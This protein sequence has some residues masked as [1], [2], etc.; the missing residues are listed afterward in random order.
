MTGSK[1]SKAYKQDDKKSIEE[2]C[3]Q[4]WE[5]LYRYVYFR[6]Q[7]RQEAEDI[8][9]EAYVKPSLGQKTSRLDHPLVPETRP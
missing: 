5:S 1:K 7:N 9:Q 4:T 2:I 3:S 8:T 6:V